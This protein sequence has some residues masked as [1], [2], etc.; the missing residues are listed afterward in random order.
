MREAARLFHSRWA[1]RG[2]ELAA[3]VAML[4]ETLFPAPIYR[5]YG[6][7]IVEGRATFGRSGIPT[8]DLA[9]FASLAEAQGIGHPI[10]QLLQGLVQA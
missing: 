4:T 6:K 3:A 7:M 9:L 8:K 1:G 2:V 5:N 10:N